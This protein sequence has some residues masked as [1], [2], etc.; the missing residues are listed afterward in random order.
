M[1]FTLLGVFFAPRAGRLHHAL[2]LYPFPQ[3]VVAIFVVRL[4]GAGRMAGWRQPLLRAA[5]FSVA[6]AVLVGSF[7]VNLKTM[8]TIRE[9]GG[10][11]LWSD[12]LMRFANELED[13][14]KTVVVSLDWG[15]DKPLRFVA[16]DLQLEEPIWRLR[17]RRNRRWNFEGSRETLYLIH[18]PGHALFSF[19][20]RFLEAV[21]R[22]PEQ[23]VSFRR[24]TDRSGDEA[25][26]SIRI[27]RPHRVR[28]RKGFKLSLD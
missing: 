14:P 12:S 8:A 27:H 21:R 24:H 1:L 20:G 18:P 2:H 4:W 7:Q 19:G 6:A 10:K 22:L 16:P 26:F 25:F 5:A 9:T 3:I 17:E 13:Q 28:Y 23:H 15:F 11:G